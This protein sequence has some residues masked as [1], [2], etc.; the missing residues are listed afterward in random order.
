MLKLQYFGH[1]MQRASSLK[2]TLMLGKIWRQEEKGTTEDE[3][4]GWMASLTQW[5]L[6]WAR[7]WR[8][9][10]TRKPGVLQSME[11]Q[12]PTW[13]SD[14][15]T[16]T[17][18]GARGKES[19]CQYRRHKRHRFN[20]WVRKIPWRRA[21]QPSPVLLPGEFYRGAYGATVHGVAKSQTWLSDYHFHVT[22]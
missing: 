19:P 22:H 2:K 4:D 7:S 1:Q 21:W 17:T 3:M 9:W 15:T 13:L 6:A 16:A 18:G 11:S 8:W 5:I 20:P 10:R 12:S 14:W